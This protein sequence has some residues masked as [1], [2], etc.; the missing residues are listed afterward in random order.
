MKRIFGYGRVSTEGQAVE[1]ISLEAQ[2]AKIQAWAMANDAEI[3]GVWVDAGVSG[4]RA[5]NR[6]E[7]QAVLEA[8]CSEGGLLVVYSL[9][10]LARSTADTLEIAGRLEAAGADLV[11]L[12][13]KIDTSSAAGKM[14]FRLL[15]VLN[16]FERD[17]VSERTKAALSH[18]RRKGERTGEVPFGF[19]LAA[20]GVRLERDENE[21][22]IIE[23]IQ[24][25]RDQGLSY[26]AIAAELDAAGMAPKK[27]LKWNAMTVRNIVLRP[28]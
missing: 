21:T 13:E 19:R 26:A 9:S 24:S 3:A 16:E 25:L 7:L 20:D 8:C 18:K 28:A 4:K 6:P 14:L 5:D 11:S 2:T 22:R 23:L 1:G 17:L 12:S 27:A 10:R 15:A